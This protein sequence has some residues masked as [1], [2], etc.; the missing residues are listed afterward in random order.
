MNKEMYTLT[1][2]V[3]LEKWSKEMPPKNGGPTLVSPSR[4]CSSTTA[5]SGQGLFSKE[6][7]NNNTLLTCV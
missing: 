7:C 1:F 3:T 6:Q 5:S 4:Q 2:F